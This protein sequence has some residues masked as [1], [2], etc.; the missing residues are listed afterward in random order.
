[1]TE[2]RILIVDDE[3][4]LSRAFQRALSLNGYLVDTLPDSKEVLANH[5]KNEY[6]LI[7]MDTEM[8]GP[9]GYEACAELR[10]HYAQVRV[11]GMSS[12]GEFQQQWMAA[13]AVHFLEKP[14]SLSLLESTI[15]KYLTKSL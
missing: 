7:L 6:D 11:I 14:F 9:Y 12:R 3:M 10:Q 2:S 4:G 1:M 15:K 13:G 8:P 5:A